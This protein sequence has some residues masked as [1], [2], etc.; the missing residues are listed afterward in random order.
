MGS[1]VSNKESLFRPGLL[2]LYVEHCGSNSLIDTY[3]KH[4]SK[5]MV[6]PRVTVHFDIKNGHIDQKKIDEELKWLRQ[7]FDRHFEA[8]HNDKVIASTLPM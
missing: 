7:N 4:P 1:T 2:I 5:I 8:S 6:T 3:M